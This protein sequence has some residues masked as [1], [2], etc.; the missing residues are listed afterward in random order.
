MSTRSIDDITGTKAKDAFPASFAN[1]KQQVKK[2]LDFLLSYNKK[3]YLKKERNGDNMHMQKSVNM[4]DTT[5]D[6]FPILN[7][8]RDSVSQSKPKFSCHIK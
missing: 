3:F 1:R 8:S 6:Y 7:L 5:K 2:P 4:R